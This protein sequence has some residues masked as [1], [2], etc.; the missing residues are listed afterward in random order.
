[1]KNLV[2]LLLGCLAGLAISLNTAKAQ[3]FISFPEKNIVSYDSSY[4]KNIN[5]DVENKKVKLGKFLRI[6]CSD[7]ASMIDPNS[8][9]IENLTH[10]F[11]LDSSVIGMIRD[12][13]NTIKN[14]NVSYESDPGQS[15]MDFLS[16]TS[17]FPM[18]F[19]NL[20]N[21]EAMRDYIKHPDQTLDDLGGDCEDLAILFSSYCL[22]RNIP[23]AI[24][25]SEEHAF[26][27]IKL[28]K[29]GKWIP[30]DITSI[31]QD[32]ETFE[33]ALQTGINSFFGD[34]PNLRII[35]PDEY[36]SLFK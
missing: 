5:F 35:I 1:M 8:E 34:F 17:Y 23:T 18:P 32:G 26:N 27:I 7:F 33:K 10:H 6:D 3:S 2:G 16:S 28:P 22:A 20:I 25:L 24:V 15:P 21:A 9:K 11:Y 13:Y 4:N 31:N 36:K 12:A 30:I 19:N 29:E 14:C